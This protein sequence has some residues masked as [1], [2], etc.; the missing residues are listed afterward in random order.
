[1]KL[2]M[3]WLVNCFLF[4]DYSGVT[5]KVRRFSYPRM[6]TRTDPH[7]VLLKNQ[8]LDKTINEAV[9]V[10]LPD[11]FIEEV[12]I[13]LSQIFMGFCPLFFLFVGAGAPQIFTSETLLTKEFWTILPISMFFQE[14]I[15]ARSSII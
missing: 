7:H 6:L 3:T 4:F 11:T 5:P 13:L 14:A 10:P 1:M 12:G 8:G 9:N 2:L 15:H